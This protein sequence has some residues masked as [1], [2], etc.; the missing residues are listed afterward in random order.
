[1]EAK[2]GL[3]MEMMMEI[4]KQMEMVGKAE[5][6]TDVELKVDFLLRNRLLHLSDPSD[7]ASYRLQSHGV[8]ISSVNVVYNH[9]FFLP[10]C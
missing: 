4:G 1:M 6:D 10:G 7:T 9:S 2:L 3:E 8:A 5:M